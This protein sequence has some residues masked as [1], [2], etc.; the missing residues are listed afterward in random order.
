[1]SNT[2]N[3]LY[4]NELLC[5]PGY[6]MNGCKIMARFMKTLSSISLLQLVHLC[7]F[8]VHGQHYYGLPHHNLLLLLLLFLL[9]QAIFNFF[10]FIISYGYYK[11][12][13][14]FCWVTNA[15]N[16]VHT[17]FTRFFKSKRAKLSQQ[18]SE[19]LTVHNALARLLQVNKYLKHI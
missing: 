8:I 19:H 14:L 11:A 1:M 5:S 2:N 9:L 15:K 17:A 6:P 18:A 16:T 13:Q 7:L 3:H 4:N 10:I 12:L